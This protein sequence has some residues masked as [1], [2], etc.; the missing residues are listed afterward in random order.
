[1]NYGSPEQP[2]NQIATVAAVSARFEI[3]CACSSLQTHLRHTYEL[4]KDMDS[5]LQQT[6]VS[7]S[8]V[9]P[10]CGLAGYEFGSNSEIVVGS[11][12]GP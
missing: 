7:R 1:M 10:H 3:A 12:M 4:Q 2:N 8:L 5:R 9:S 6:G 11:L